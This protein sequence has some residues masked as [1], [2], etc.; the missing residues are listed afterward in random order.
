MI[1]CLVKLLLR[2]GKFRK[3]YWTHLINGLVF[4]LCLYNK[5]LL[6]VKWNLFSIYKI[7]WGNVQQEGPAQSI[8]VHP[9]GVQ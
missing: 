2:T 7:D 1:K 4:G 6:G 3:Y 9:K 5:Y 8:S